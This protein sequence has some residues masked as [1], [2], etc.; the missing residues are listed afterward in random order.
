MNNLN[1]ILIEGNMTSDPQMRTTPFGKS[2]CTFSIAN[3]RFYKKE[4]APEKEVSFYDV[5]AWSRL[6]ESCNDLGRKGRGVR[7]VGRLKQER[8]SGSDGKQHSR[9]IIAAEHVEFR[10]DFKKQDEAEHEEES[11]ITE[12]VTEVIPF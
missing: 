3:N 7:V 1:S 11:V 6:A 10:T 8:W 2:V 9:V 5:E 4:G 12:E